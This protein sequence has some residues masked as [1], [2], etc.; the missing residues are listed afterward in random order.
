[1]SPPCATVRVLLAILVTTLARWRLRQLV[2]LT[3]SDVNDERLPVV[4]PIVDAREAT[5]VVLLAGT[6]V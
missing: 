2:Y 5:I 6:N 4:C 1:M 3:L